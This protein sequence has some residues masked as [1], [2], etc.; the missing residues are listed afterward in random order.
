MG[1]PGER[2]NVSDCLRS[3]SRERLREEPPRDQERRNRRLVV[4]EAEQR[5]EREHERER[6]YGDRD[7]LQHYWGEN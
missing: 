1:P 6:E 3:Q 5:S 2:G 7:R 4:G